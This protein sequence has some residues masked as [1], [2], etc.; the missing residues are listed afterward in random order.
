PISQPEFV[1]RARLLS[2]ISLRG[3]ARPNPTDMGV[4]LCGLESDPALALEQSLWRFAEAYAGQLKN[5]LPEA[6]QRLGLLRFVGDLRKR[7]QDLEGR[8]NARTATL[9]VSNLGAVD[10]L[11]D[12]RF[13]FIQGNHY[14]GPL[15]NLSVATCAQRGVLRGTLAT[16]APG[17]AP[18]VAS[19]F[20]RVFERAV[21]ACAQGEVTFG[22][23]LRRE[24]GTRA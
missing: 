14:H 4:Y 12:T 17:V 10:G 19:R 2:P 3:L 15:F 22:A 18:Q 23:F 1:L 21:A 24:A 11:G 5:A 20:V 6:Y 13:W 8:A 16:P 7:A 9:E